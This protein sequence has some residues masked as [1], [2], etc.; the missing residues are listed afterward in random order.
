MFAS[1]GG[2]GGGIIAIAGISGPGILSRSSRIYPAQFAGNAAAGT[3]EDAWKPAP[4]TLL[5][6]GLG[7]LGIGLSLELLPHTVEVGRSGLGTEWAAPLIVYRPSASTLSMNQ[8]LLWASQTRPIAHTYSCCGVSCM[9]AQPVHAS[10]MIGS[11]AAIRREGDPFGASARER[12]AMATSFDGSN[13][14]GGG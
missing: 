13:L 8:V 12:A 4:A 2:N 14:I 10:K 1:I 6:L 11:I 3:D 9:E 5:F 7:P